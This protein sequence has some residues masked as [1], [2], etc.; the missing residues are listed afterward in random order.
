M[1][2]KFLLLSFLFLGY[3]RVNSNVNALTKEQNVECNSNSIWSNQEHNIAE[4]AATKF[5]NAL[6]FKDMT[7]ISEQ[8]SYPMELVDTNDNKLKFINKK[9]FLSFKFDELFSKE[10]V[11]TVISSN[12]TE[13]FSSWR[14]FM[15]GDG[16][17]TVWFSPCEKE[18]CLIYG[19]VAGNQLPIKIIK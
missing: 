9:G 5:I 3:S 10:F 13:M 14:G 18:N 17:N 2:I 7:T 4:K 15:L 8:I 16:S 6:K 19:I 12:P 11:N 1:N